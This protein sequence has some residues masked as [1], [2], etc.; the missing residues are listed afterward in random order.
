MPRFT[1]TVRYGRRGYRY[2]TFDVD[3]ADVSEALE[4][5]AAGLAPDIRE[6][7]DLV[8]V[9]PAHEPGERK[10]LGESGS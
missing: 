4:E 10:F 2:H 8:E 9:R 5:A 7:A 1:V 3:A 6:T